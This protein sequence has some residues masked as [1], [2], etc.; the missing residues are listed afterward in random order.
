MNSRF[1]KQ[2]WSWCFST[3]TEKYPIQVLKVRMGRHIR[4]KYWS[5]GL[6]LL[7][8]IEGRIHFLGAVKSQQ[9]PVLLV[10]P[11]PCRAS[12]PS[13][14]LPVRLLRLFFLSLLNL[15]FSF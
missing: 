6:C 11:S 5:S 4:V 13:P 14:H 1:Y 10:D 12:Y 8:D 9:P 2:P 3:A 7:L 15:V